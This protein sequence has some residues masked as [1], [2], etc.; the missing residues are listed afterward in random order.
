MFAVWY[1]NM[2][3]ELLKQLSELRE[4]TDEKSLM[5]QSRSIFDIDKL[6]GILLLPFTYQNWGEERV[7]GKRAIK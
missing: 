5:L 6:T 3:F 2:L 7:L 1:N 4:G